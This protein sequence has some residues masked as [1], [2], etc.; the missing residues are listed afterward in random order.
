MEWFVSHGMFWLG[1][2]ECDA[3]KEVV[4]LVFAARAKAR[5]LGFDK[6]YWQCFPESGYKVMKLVKKGLAKVDFVQCYM[7]V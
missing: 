3:P 4:K 6:M 2:L 7:D 1:S 5:E